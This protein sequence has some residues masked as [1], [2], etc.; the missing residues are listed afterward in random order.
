M[1]VFV[2]R[3]NGLF[4]Q[5]SLYHSGGKK[6]AGRPIAQ[7]PTGRFTLPLRRGRNEV[8]VGVANGFYGW[9]LIFQPELRP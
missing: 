3:Q 9:G 7:P 4:Q 6:R 8:V 5:K 2:K 1:W